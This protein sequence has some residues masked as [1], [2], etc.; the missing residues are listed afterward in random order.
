MRDLFAPR[1]APW[2]LTKNNKELELDMTSPKSTAA[3]ADLSPEQRQALFDKLRQRKLTDA[4][5]PSTPMPAQPLASR[6]LSPAQAA[7][8]KQLTNA[9][10]R[11]VELVTEGPVDGD[12]L[13]RHLRHLVRHHDALAL[14]FTSDGAVPVAPDQA[15]AFHRP[16]AVE[17][18]ATQQALEQMR[19]QL[20]AANADSAPL[21]AAWLS[22]GDRG[23][24]LLAAHPLLLDAYSLL[25]FA[26]QW[27]SL[28]AGDVSLEAIPPTVRAAADGFAHWSGQVMEQKFLAQEWTRLKPK[29]TTASAQ[30]PGTA[31]HSHEILFLAADFITRHCPEDKSTKHWMIDAIHRCLNRWLSHQETLFWFNTPQLRDDQ[32]ESLLGFFPYYVPVAPLGADQETLASQRIMRL[33]TRFSPVSEQLSVELCSKGSPVPLIHYHWFDPD[34]SAN[35]EL[36]IGNVIHHQSG[37]LFAP[38]EI[39]ITELLAGVSL[40][41]H[42]DPGHIGLDQVNFL[43][44]DLLVYLREEKPNASSEPPSLHERLRQIW[45]DLLQKSEIGDDQSFFELG[46]HSLQVTELK[47]RIKQQLQLDVPISVLYELT[48][49]N[50]LVNFILATQSGG[51]GFNAGNEISDEEEEEGIL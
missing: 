21:Q 5:R 8:L 11:V 29:G 46:G 34:N 49:I 28:Y 25:R 14:R 15:L 4:R 36:K 44:R 33:Q 48:T 7:R 1:P 35:P 37:F 47:F 31:E 27:L 39:H 3:F 12:A 24:L 17:E 13:E 2:P 23:H 9:P 6:A 51:L 40:D 45:Q 30:Q 18:T 20:T 32:F 41:V 26:N 19:L 43:L 22:A 10:N 38:V 16:P 42:Y 50:K